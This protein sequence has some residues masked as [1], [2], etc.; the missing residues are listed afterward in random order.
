MPTPEVLPL[1]FPSP[2]KPPPPDAFD[3]IGVSLF[4]RPG[5]EMFVQGDPGDTVYRVLRGAVRASRLLSD[6]RRQIS[7][8]Y[9]DGD[10]FGLETGS[11]RHASAEALVDTRVLVVRRSSLKYYGAVGET[12]ERALW[13]ATGE[14]LT[15]ALEHMMLVARKS[16]LERVAGFLGEIAERV[17]GDWVDLPM[18]RQDIA[19]FLGLTIETI[20]RMLTQLQQDE[21]VEFRGCRRFRIKAPSRIAGLLAA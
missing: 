12:L 17:G 4:Y 6:G 9:Y 8:F 11:H 10:L 14:A 20:S 16:A 19:D 2:A 13:S 1:P 15:R 18:P 3:C 7:G 21:V 5:E